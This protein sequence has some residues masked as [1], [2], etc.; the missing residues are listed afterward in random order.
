LKQHELAKR[1]WKAPERTPHEEVELVGVY[2]SLRFNY[3]LSTFSNE[4]GFFFLS[5]SAQIRQ[6]AR[7]DALNSMNNNRL[8]TEL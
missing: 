2:V 1:S 3:F 5:L 6:K 7:A 8:K 4:F